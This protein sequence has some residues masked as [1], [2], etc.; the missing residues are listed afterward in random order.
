MENDAGGGTSIGYEFESLARVVE[1]AG[2]LESGKLGLCFD[3]CHAFSAGYDL[4]TAATFDATMEHYDA[5]L[6]VDNVRVLHLND[7]AKP[8]RSRRDRHDDLGN[9][10]DVVCI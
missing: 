2:G 1:H 5:L 7:S 4:R 10:L 6:G 9:L 3:T 8:F